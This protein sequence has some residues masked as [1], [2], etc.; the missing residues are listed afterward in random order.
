[1]KTI[2]KGTKK[3]IIL[4]ILLSISISYLSLQI[5]LYIKYAIDGILYENAE[6]P[7]YL[8]NAMHSEKIK[9]LMLIAT[10]M[11]LINVILFLMKYIRDKVTTKFVLK[12]KTDFK[13]ILYEHILKL[14]YQDYYSYEQ[15]EM[16]QRVNDDAEVYA[17]FFKKFFNLILDIFT[18]SYFILTKGINLSLPITVYIVITI[19]VMIAFILW[20]HKRL[21]QSLENLIIKKK[22]L[23]GTTINNI[24]HFKLIRVFNKQKEEIEKY[25]KLNE[26]CKE[27]DIKLIKLILFYEI[28]NDHI[29]YLKTPII[30]L[31]GGISIMKGNMTFGSLEA[32]IMFAGKL[33]DCF[34]ILGANLE[35]IDTFYVVNKKINNLMKLKEE[36]NKYYHYELDGDII[37]HNVSINIDDTL[38]L[39]NLNFNIK[40]GEKVAIVGENGSGKSILAKTIMGFYPIEGDIYFNYHNIKQLNKENIREYIDYISG[41]SEMFSGTVKENL[42][43]D[44]IYEETT[45]KQVLKDSEILKD[46][47]KFE[48]KLETFIG[49][50]GVKLSGG[51]K[52]RILIARA[53]LRNKPIMIFDNVFNKL[54]SETREKILKNLKNR[55]SDKTIIFITH[56][57]NIE[58]NVDKI[59]NLK[60]Q[61]SYVIFAIDQ[62]LSK[63]VP[64]ISLQNTKK[65]EYRK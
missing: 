61:S 33:M 26:E 21:N 47:Q 51:Q 10:I 23:L 9:G 31:L 27:Q 64:T 7:Q 19:F 32:L 16:M 48:N 3:H 6:I 39:E 42:E 43:I 29:T 4:L 15:T 52:Q 41:D 18:L 45:L 56:D 35:T 36:E 12:I 49:E 50:K 54:D 59:I 22:S 40:K 17:G 24:S 8:L 34:L 65:G 14:E 62:T 60:N 20:Y 13:L 44:K 63:T 53:L 57:E 25:E 1:M 58:Q 30:Y 37:F 46:I 2:L 28:I 55:Y 38:I 11:L 5:A